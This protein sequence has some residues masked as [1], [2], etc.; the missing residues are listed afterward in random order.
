MFY[1]RYILNK[2]III[3]AD[4][5]CD[6][7]DE[8]QR[9]FDV[10]LF[11]FH[12][13]LGNESFIDGI[14]ITPDELYAAWRQRGIL[15]KT[16]AIT[17]ADYHEYFHKWIEDGYEVIHINVGSGISASYQNCCIAASEIGHIF[18]VDSANLSTGVALLVVKAG[19]MAEAGLTAQEIQQKLI[20][21][22]EKSHA[23]FVL[24]TLE[25]MRAGGR[26]SAVAAFGANLLRLKP[27]IL[28]NNRDGANM[29]VG[30]KYRGAM[31]NV[32]AMYVEDNLKGR[33]DLDLSRV[34]ITHSGSPDSDIELVKAEVMKYADFKKIYV[35]R[36][37]GTISSHCGPRTLG[38][39]FMTK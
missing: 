5:A 16:A 2:K 27:E 25:F 39:L 24:D 22:R 28:V 17:P 33:D 9:Q 14:E 18:P 13:H 23:S 15:P 36:A 8:L 32:L 6:I 10:Q 26:C 30:K 20:A 3:S 35:T 19:E 29:S 7:G 34:F 11:H 37:S 21:M 12:I 4:A 1:A 38:V 31:E